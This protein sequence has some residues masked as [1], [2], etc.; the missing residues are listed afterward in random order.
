MAEALPVTVE[1]ELPLEPPSSAGLFQQMAR[2][3]QV[4]AGK[5]WRKIQIGAKNGA[6][7]KL[8]QKRR[9]MP[10]NSNWREMARNSNWLKKCREI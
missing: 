6:K 2:I 7:F 4:S 5:E 9:K 10:R 1:V 3:F 8:K